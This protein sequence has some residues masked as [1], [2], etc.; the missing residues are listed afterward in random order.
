MSYLVTTLLHVLGRSRRPTYRRLTT[1]PST[2][3]ADA[4]D[5]TPPVSWSLIPK[6]IGSDDER[7]VGTR[8]GP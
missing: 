2:M 6:A 7:L 3:P 1:M 4:A 5:T 8:R